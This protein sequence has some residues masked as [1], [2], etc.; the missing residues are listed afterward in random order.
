[1]SNFTREID[2]LSHQLSERL[3]WD[4]Y[5]VSIALLVASRSPCHR[6]HVGSVIV[7]DNRILC[8]GYNGFIENAPHT[9]RIRDN[10]EMGTV[11]A[12]Q[13]AIADA[14]ARGVSISGAKVY[15]THYPCIHCAKILAASKISHIIYYKDYRNDDL[16]PCILK[17][18][19]ICISQFSD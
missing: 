1:M 16:V 17:D 10:H 2:R 7:K 4:E 6:L 19:N 3:K 18:A 9:S 11:H 8:V 12:E 13:N 5:F 14:A 15:I